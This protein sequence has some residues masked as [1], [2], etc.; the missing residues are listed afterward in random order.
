VFVFT[1]H[2][3]VKSLPPSVQ[4]AYLY[5]TGKRQ[6]M[7]FAQLVQPLCKCHTVHAKVWRSRVFVP[8]FIVLPGLAGTGDVRGLANY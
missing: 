4:L 8:T 5:A 1:L 7:D 2:N 3:T 6:R